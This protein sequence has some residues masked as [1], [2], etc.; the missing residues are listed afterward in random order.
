VSRLI[1][2]GSIAAVVY[3]YVLYPALLVVVAR[4]R[5]RQVRR[6]PIRPT[7]SLLIAAHNEARW[8]ARK[9]ESCLALDYPLDKLEIVVA[10]DGSDDETADIARRYEPRGVA[11]WA[12]E[13]RRGKPSVLNAVVPKLHGQIVVLADAR[14]VFEPGALVAL[15]EQFADPDVGAVSGELVVTNAAGTAV[16]DG[17][18]FYWRYEKTIRY[19]ESRCDSA[20]GATGAIYAIRRE[21]FEPIPADTL[22]DDV[23]IPMTIVRRGYRVMFEPDAKALDEASTSPAQEFARK[24]R[25]IAGNFQLFLRHPWLLH[26][27]RNRLWLQ[28]VSHK[29]LRLLGPMFLLAI[30]V[31]NSVLYR[32]S[33]YQVTLALQGLLYLAAGLG[34]AQG[35]GSRGH[36]WLSVP[37]AFCFLNVITVISFFRFVTG[38]QT[39]TWSRVQQ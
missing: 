2:W 8:I 26:P 29:A 38:R 20:V 16:A 35:G 5:P 28:T 21:L 3:T 11:V 19:H 18:G 4:L 27:H 10:S 14:Q 1:F 17:V 15:V 31:S 36:R 6:G 24:V 23:L 30:L 13:H 12:F 25:T 39:V 7:V 32:E 34:W 33:F 37:Y 9:L 22:L